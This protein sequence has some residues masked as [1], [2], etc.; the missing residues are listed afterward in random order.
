MTKY[1]PWFD[2]SNIKGYLL[3][4]AVTGLFS[5]GAYHFWLS[6]NDKEK[7][8]QLIDVA[9]EDKFKILHKKI[10]TYGVTKNMDY[11]KS[12]ALGKSTVLSKDGK[13][14]ISQLLQYY[15]KHPCADIVKLN[16]KG[17]FEYLFGKPEMPYLSLLN[18]L[19]AF[20]VGVLSQSDDPEEELFKKSRIVSELQNY[21]SLVASMEYNSLFLDSEW[22]F[23]QEYKQKIL[24]MHDLY[25][26]CLESTQDKQ[27]CKKLFLK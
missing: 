2:M 18:S 1:S 25:D 6:R 24:S 20:H 21:E 15:L 17:D 13:N 12:F 16:Y 23:P 7:H 5:F 26:L 11:R 8:N 10:S 22:K 19:V 27:N 4:N 9:S 3:S 14:D